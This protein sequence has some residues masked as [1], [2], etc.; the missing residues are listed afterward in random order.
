[1]VLVEVGDVKGFAEGSKEIELN[2]Q[3]RHAV[4]AHLAAGRDDHSEVALGLI[5]NAARCVAFEQIAEIGATG[6]HDR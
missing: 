4:K 6:R 2:R 3:E 1:M 5:I